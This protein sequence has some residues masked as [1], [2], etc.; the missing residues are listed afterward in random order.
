M[1]GRPGMF[2]QL[3]NVR[4][5]VAARDT[6]TRYNRPTVGPF[7]QVF[8]LSYFVF[9]WFFRFVRAFALS[10]PLAL[11]IYG[12]FAV[13]ANFRAP[14]LQ[15][16]G[17]VFTYFCNMGFYPQNCNVELAKK[18]PILQCRVYKIFAHFRQQY[19]RFAAFHL[20]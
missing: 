2:H 17:R 16:F 4:P 14:I 3:R 12:F 19:G 20:L 15:I 6:Q 7:R 5:H 13:L 9:Y 10:F 8:V 1:W 11:Q 18:T